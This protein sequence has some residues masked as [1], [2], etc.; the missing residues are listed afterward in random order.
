M[1]RSLG[2]MKAGGDVDG[3]L[4]TL[5][6]ELDYRG[7]VSQIYRALSQAPHLRFKRTIGN[8]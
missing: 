1:S 3:I 7:L 4:K 5:Q 8:W 2:F 6:K